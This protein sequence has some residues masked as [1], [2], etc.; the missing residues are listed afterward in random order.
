MAQAIVR[1]CVE[2]EVVLALNGLLPESIM[3]IRAA[4]NGLLPQ[5][6]IRVWYA[7]GPTRECDPSNALRRDIA[8]LVREAF[9][10]S[11]SP[12]VVLVTSLF[13]GIG[14]DAVTSVGRFDT[15]TPTAVI[16]HDLI[17]LISPDIDFRTNPVHIGFYGQKIKSLKRSTALL[18]NSESSRNEALTALHFRAQQ[19]TTISAA[20]DS[21]F[22]IPDM[23]EREKR[24]LCAKLAINKPF[25]MYTGGS[26]ERKNLVRLISAFASLPS[27][28]R[29]QYQLLMVGKMSDSQ[30]TDFTKTIKKVGLTAT[31]VVFTG[32]VSDL[33]LMQL[34]SLCQLFVFPSL[35]EG[36]GL[37]LLEAMACGAPVIA[38]NATSLP[39]VVGCED[40]LFDPFS[41]TAISE[42]IKQVLID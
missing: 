17:P 38:A 14:D 41:T 7:L 2:H 35:H 21:S 9:I 27:E 30:L 10:T 36:F 4:F 22:H 28:L 12:D 31:D 5:T 33:E 39:E 34:Y 24:L 19:I 23:T 13:E 20:C 1:N 40:A 26:D 6:N 18:S 37:P 3:P 42:K 8:E 11:L 29:S 25:L 16:L 32:Y 15:E